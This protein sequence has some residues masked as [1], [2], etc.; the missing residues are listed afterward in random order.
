MD[1]YQKN[2]RDKW[3]FY[4]NTEY[5]D[6]AIF[7]DGDKLFQ[8]QNDGKIVDSFTEP[9]TI[10]TVEKAEQIA[11]EYMAE[12]LQEEMLDNADDIEFQ[13]RSPDLFRM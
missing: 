11:D 7:W 8:V 13:F 6:V 12:K 5:G 4:G 1:T 9:E 2:L 3:F 10:A